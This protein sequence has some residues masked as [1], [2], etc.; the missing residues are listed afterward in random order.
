MK[1]KNRSQPYYQQKPPVTKK[2]STQK[3]TIT[4]QIKTYQIENFKKFRTH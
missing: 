2:M 3:L 4:K 1:N